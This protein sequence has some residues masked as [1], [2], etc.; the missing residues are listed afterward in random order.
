MPPSASTGQLKNMGESPPARKAH[1]H[2]MREKA[3]SISSTFEMPLPV[4]GDMKKR[5][6]TKPVWG[7]TEPPLCAALNYLCLQVDRN[8]EGH[9]GLDRVQSSSGLLPSLPLGTAHTETE[10]DIGP[11]NTFLLILPPLSQNCDPWR[12]GE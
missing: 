12:C 3:G 6:S 2:E 11:L 10:L 7:R 8:L 5:L 4:R 1:A 9:P